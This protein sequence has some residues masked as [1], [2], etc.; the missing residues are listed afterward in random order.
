MHLGFKGYGKIDLNKVR[1]ATFSGDLVYVNRDLLNYMAYTKVD[2][3]GYEYA[4]DLFDFARNPALFDK[5]L[6]L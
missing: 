6:S 4:C 5:L 1:A 3:D 2:P